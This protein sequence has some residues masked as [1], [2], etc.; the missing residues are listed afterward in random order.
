MKNLKY[1]LTS[2]ALFVILISCNKDAVM[3]TIDPSDIGSVDAAFTSKLLVYKLTEAD[4]GQLKIL[5]QRGNASSAA[6]VPVTVAGAGLSHFTLQSNSVQF[7]VGEYQKD[8]ILTYKFA[9]I[10]PGNKYVFEVTITDE[11]MLSKSKVSKIKVEAEI[12]LSYKSLGNGVY[13]S[14]FFEESWDQPVMKADITPT[15]AFYLLPGCYYSGFDIMF[16]V[17]NGVMEMPSQ[18]SGYYYDATHGYAF[19]TPQSTQISGKKH[20]VIAKFTLPKSGAGFTGVFE[21]SITLP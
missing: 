10:A 17:T 2:F 6:T 7:A 20:S 21:E 3:Q 12:A 9:N 4:N 18:S 14:E 19:I 13:S 5:I 8:I 1:I 16:S 15:F 11:T